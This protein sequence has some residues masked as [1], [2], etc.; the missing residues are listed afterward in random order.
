MFL[1]ENCRNRG[2]PSVNLS[3]GYS[4]TQNN[5]KISSQT[6]NLSGEQVVYTYDALNRL[7]SAAA[8]SNSWGQGYSYDGFSNLT[9]QRVTAGS[10]PSY[11]V[12]PNGS[13]NHLGGEDAN[14]NLSPVPNGQFDVEN[15]FIGAY[16]YESDSYTYS[17]APVNK[18]VWRQVITAGA[19]T[20]DEITVWSVSGKKLAT[21]QLSMNGTQ[22]ASAAQTGTYY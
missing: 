11:S 18:R 10:A 4:S 6:D 12:T 9:G 7:A 14:G 20:T 22:L 17:Y 5:G 1:A 15:R 16:D 21:H 13:T 2:G 8:T 3:Y 19:V